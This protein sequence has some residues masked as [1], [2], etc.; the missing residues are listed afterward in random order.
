[1]PEPMTAEHLA[2]ENARLWKAI[3]DR[4]TDVTERRS[5]SRST[6]YYTAVGVNVFGRCI[7]SVRNDDGSSTVFDLEAYRNTNYPATHERGKVEVQVRTYRDDHD[8]FWGKQLRDC[9][10]NTRVV[11]DHQHYRIVREPRPGTSDHCRGFGGREHTVEFFDG[12]TVTTRNLWH[13]GVIPP[14]W[15]DRLPDN[16]RFVQ[17]GD[18]LDLATVGLDG[19]AA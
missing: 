14:A 10:D 7:C 9:D 1:M 13:Q 4:I 18:R 16:A 8:E 6:G 12:R 3:L 5:H 17:P 19:G 15:R 11:V 2:E